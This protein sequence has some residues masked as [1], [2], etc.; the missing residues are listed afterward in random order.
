MSRERRGDANWNVRMR[1][2]TGT[3]YRLEDYKPT[4]YAAVSIDLLF[5]LDAGKTLVRAITVFSRRTNTEAGTPLIL[6]GDGL[7]LVSIKVE[8]KSANDAG[9][10]VDG[11]RLILSSPPTE[12]IFSLE[13]ETEIDPSSN[14]A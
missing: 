7:K 12:A 8:G 4:D 1:T 13:I 11:A 9:L 6:D 14:R 2:D 5:R 3:I 10:T